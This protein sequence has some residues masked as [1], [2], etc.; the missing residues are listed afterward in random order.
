MLVV[1]IAVQ[2]IESNMIIPLVMARTTRL[3]PAVIAIGVLA[4]GQPV[5]DRG[6]VRGRP[7]HLRGRDPDRGD[8]GEGDRAADERRTAEALEGAA[9]RGA[10]SPSG[11]ADRLCSSRAERASE[12][13]SQSEPASPRGEARSRS[14]SRR[15]ARSRRVRPIGAGAVELEA[16]G[17][18]L[19]GHVVGVLAHDVEQSRRRPRAR[20]RSGPRP[21][22]RR[23]CARSAPRARPR[24]RRPR[25]AARRRGRA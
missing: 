9:A 25:R 19:A 24:G 8:L 12:A 17:E 14:P 11:R 2:Q 22:G 4:V 5:R 23:P 3:H 18:R 13:T 1:Y 20:A 10:R 15:C 16:V 6:P 7:D 21:A